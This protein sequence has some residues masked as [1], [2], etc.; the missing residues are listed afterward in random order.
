MTNGKPSDLSDLAFARGAL[1]RRDLLRRAGVAGGVLAGSGLL[2]A[3]GGGSSSSSGSPASSSAP[4]AK[5]SID[6]ADMAPTWTF[7]NWPLYIDTKGKTK[8]P[9]LDK[10][11]AAYQTTTKYLEDIED[12]ESFFGQVKAQLEAGQ[13]IDRDIVVLTDWMAGKWILLG[14]AE[15]LD[16][17]ALPNVVAN[18]GTAWQ[19]RP[20][21]KNDEYLVPWQSGMT[22]IGYNPKLTGGKLSSVKDLWNPEFKG[23]VTLLTE[24]RDT[25]GLV[26]LSM[27]IDPANCTVDDAQAAVDEI[28]PYVDNGQIRR[29]TGND[30]AGDLAKGNVVAC[31]AWSGDIVQLQFDNP[32]LEFLVPDDGAML[33]TDNMLIPKNAANPQNAHAWMNFYYQP[34]IGA[35]VEDWVNYICPID[36]AKEVLLKDDPGIANNPLI[37]PPAD[38]QDKLHVFKLLSPQEDLEFNQLFQG[39]IGA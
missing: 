17:S 23:K 10:F 39:L 30:Y 9:S 21:D 25:L 4:A 18:Q 34:E 12:N 6:P 33:W 31:M 35:M 5:I 27:G 16:K 20:I 7:S 8:H 37:F 11:D 36:G 22:G 3:C 14:Y 1:T 13:S 28:K 15:K 24:M 29:F 32:D 2:A 19:G 38:V 26:M